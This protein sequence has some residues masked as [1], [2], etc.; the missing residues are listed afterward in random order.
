M[1]SAVFVPQLEGE[2]HGHELGVAVPHQ[3]RA[4]RVA[5]IREVVDEPTTPPPPRRR[6]TVEPIRRGAVDV[7]VGKQFDRFVTMATDA[8]LAVQP[9]GHL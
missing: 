1:R 5:L 8:G 7:G 3:L 4:G 6:L 2:G 9:S